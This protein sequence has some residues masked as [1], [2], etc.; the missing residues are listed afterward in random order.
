MPKNKIRIGIVG[1][2]IPRKGHEDLVDACKLLKEDGV[3]FELLIYGSG[4]PDYIEL[5]KNLIL[6]NNLT[7]DVH[8]MGFEKDLNNIYS[9]LDVMVA[10]TRNEEPFALV[11]LEAAAYKVPVIA[12]RSGGFPESVL[13]NKTGFLV[14]KN[15]PEMIA[16]KIKLLFQDPSKLKIFGENGR[17][18]VMNQFTIEHM[19]KKMEKVINLNERKPF[20]QHS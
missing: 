4:F 14:D 12:S 2:V 13:D 20:I 6:K 1:Q 10:P 3:S 18:N 11:A 16:Q 19:Q 5:V 17:I 8:W 15:A 7:N 9:K